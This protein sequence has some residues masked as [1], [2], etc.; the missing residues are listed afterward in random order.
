MLMASLAWTLKAWFALM[1]PVGSERESLND[2]RDLILAMEF[3]TFL[4][5]LI[6]IPAQV[7]RSGRRIILRVLAWRQH[8]HLLF[9]LAA[10][11]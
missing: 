6:L 10:A 11:L 9:R 4:Q 3:R 1:L 8:G 2:E 5:Q 7:I